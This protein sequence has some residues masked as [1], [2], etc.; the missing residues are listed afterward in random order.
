MY[1]RHE[2]ARARHDVAIGDYKE[3]IYDRRDTKP[4]CVVCKEPT[5]GYFDFS[6]CCRGTD[7]CKDCLDTWMARGGHKCPVCRKTFDAPPKQISFDSEEE[8]AVEAA[9]EIV[10]KRK[11]EIRKLVDECVQ[12]LPRGA[13]QMLVNPRVDAFMHDDDDGAELKL[14]TTT[15]PELDWATLLG[16]KFERLRVLARSIDMHG[17]GGEL[18][19]KL[20]Q[21]AVN[22]INARYLTSTTEEYLRKIRSATRIYRLDDHLPWR[23]DADVILSATSAAIS[24][25][26]SYANPIIRVD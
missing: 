9:F 14:D 4:E 24:P 8:K 6:E 19:Q 10:C 25:H 2:S 12:S 16:D 23:G 1:N 21:E 13:V 26:S 15:L 18:I 20:E 7:V 11:D 3:E 22:Q 5:T 17:E